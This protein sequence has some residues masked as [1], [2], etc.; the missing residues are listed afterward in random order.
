MARVLVFERFG[1]TS[2]EATDGLRS[3]YEIVDVTDLGATEYG[4]GRIHKFRVTVRKL[5]IGVGHGKRTPGPGED[6]R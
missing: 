4:G 5:P 3:E 1:R 2:K 6:W